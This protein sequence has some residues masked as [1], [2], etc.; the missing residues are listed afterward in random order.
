MGTAAISANKWFSPLSSVG[1]S[2]V[3]R[4]SCLSQVFGTLWKRPALRWGCSKL[5]K[6]YLVSVKEN[7]PLA[8]VQLSEQR[9][10]PVHPA[11]SHAYV[12]AAVS[13]GCVGQGGQGEVAN[14]ERNCSETWLWRDIVS[15]SSA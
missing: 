12:P 7:S 8:L 11:G 9:P 2:S 6:T 3:P 5:P 1:A 4:A 14:A 15:E 10:G 13:V